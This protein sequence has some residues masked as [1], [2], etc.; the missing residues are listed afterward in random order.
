MDPSNTVLH[1]KSLQK[2]KATLS[3]TLSSGMSSK[4]SYTL[5]TLFVVILCLSHCHNCDARPHQ[6]SNR[7]SSGGVHTLLPCGHKDTRLEI[8]SSR[9]SHGST[10]ILTNCLLDR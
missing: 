3:K 9:T 6:G 1:A 5:A 2:T 8:R 7:S 10:S 4:T